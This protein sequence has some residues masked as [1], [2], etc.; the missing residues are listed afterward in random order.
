MVDEVPEFFVSW[1]KRKSLTIHSWRLI[2]FAVGALFIG[3]A[4]TG[5]AM[6]D[7]N[8]NGLSD[9]WE[10]VYGAGGLAPGGDADGD[11]FSNQQEAVAGTN[12][13]DAN[14]YP[15]ISSI[16]V[17]PGTNVSAVNA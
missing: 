9:V 12:P 7:A 1:S 16:N 5:R 2:F 11:G 6:V 13:F 3:G 17:I 8:G 14:S 4:G 15:G 10:Q